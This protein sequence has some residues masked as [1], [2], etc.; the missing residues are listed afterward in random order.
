MTC[1]GHFAAAAR[2]TLIHSTSNLNGPAFL[3]P[4][5]KPGAL[6]SVGFTGPASS[7][8]LP[9]EVAS[10]L[11]SRILT[12]IA[13]ALLRRHSGSGTSEATNGLGTVSVYAADGRWYNRRRM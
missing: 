3:S 2:T 4:G 6:T 12:S 13:L 5:K 9:N 7:T 1:L 11:S 10:N 8:G